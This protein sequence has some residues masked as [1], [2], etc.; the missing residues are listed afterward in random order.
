MIQINLNVFYY[1]I[2]NKL[3]WIM[4][5]Y[6]PN[7]SVWICFIAKLISNLCELDLMSYFIL[8]IMTILMRHK[9]YNLVIMVL[10]CNANKHVLKPF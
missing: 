10:M 4:L 8:Q 9:L 2:A 3:L 1:V 7:K 5:L 6:N